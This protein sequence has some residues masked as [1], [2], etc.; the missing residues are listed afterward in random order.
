MGHSSY[1]ENLDVAEP[2]VPQFVLI[3]APLVLTLQRDSD[4]RPDRG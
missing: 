1:N 3:V 2:L 4:E